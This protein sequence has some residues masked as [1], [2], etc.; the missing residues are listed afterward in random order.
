MP[1][2][3]KS[4][5]IETPRERPGAS[6]EDF[7]ADLAALDDPVG[8]NPEPA[9]CLAHRLG[10][11]R[12]IQAIGLLRVGAQEGIEPPDA[13]IVVDARDL[14]YRVAVQLEPFGKIPFDEK[15]G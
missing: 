3:C 1:A 6:G 13:D 10:A 8:R 4:R 12:L 11:R 2:P 15:E 5:L 7:G 9:R 14:A